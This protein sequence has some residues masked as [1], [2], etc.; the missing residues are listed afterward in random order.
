MPE[1][2]T[3]PVAA[4]RHPNKYLGT[5]GMFWLM[6]LLLAIYTAPKTFSIGS[7]VFSVGILSYPFTYIFSDIFTEV[8]GYRVTRRIVWTGFVCIILASLITFIYSIIPP[9]ESYIHDE[10]FNLIFRIGPVITLA[11]II[12][13]FSGELTNS[14]VLAKLKIRSRGNREGVRYIASTFCGQVVDNTIF[15]TVVYAIS[16]V[17]ASHELIPIILSS[18]AFCTLWEMCM[19]P[20]TT[21]IIRYVKFKEGLDAYDHGTNFSPFSWK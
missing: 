6:F 10:A 11:I 8:Y 12:S 13:F 7:V 20:L 1:L 5:F 21:R 4:A 3:D 15:Y 19:L 2:I 18:V 14:F 9:S 17:Y 16:G